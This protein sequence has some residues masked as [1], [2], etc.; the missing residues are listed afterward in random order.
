MYEYAAPDDWLTIRPQ[1][2]LTMYGATHCYLR[3]FDEKVLSIESRPDFVNEFHEM[4]LD[5]LLAEAEADA[6]NGLLEPF[7]GPITDEELNAIH[8][9]AL[10]DFKKICQ[11]Q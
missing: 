8:Q 9:L 4:T 5:A 11:L 3:A 10:E 7:S 2:C 1:F 6:A